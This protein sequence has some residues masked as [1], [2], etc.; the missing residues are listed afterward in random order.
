MNEFYRMLDHDHRE[1][2]LEPWMA[3]LHDGDPL[4]DAALLT[5]LDCAWG[6]WDR[7]ARAGWHPI[8]EPNYRKA[9][10]GLPWHWD[11]WIPNALLD[12]GFTVKRWRRIIAAM[13]DL[14]RLGHEIAIVKRDLTPPYDAYIVAI[15]DDRD[16]A[17]DEACMMSDPDH[18][19]ECLVWNLRNLAVDAIRGAEDVEHVGD[20]VRYR[21]YGSLG[22]FDYLTFRRC[23][24]D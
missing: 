1:E 2:E 12:R 10:K 24:A 3:G 5:A 21:T 8:V 9:V 20:W 14:G 22:G 16:I 23:E 19:Y 18:G 4:T 6:H 15:E 13:N 17:D 7:A 11:D